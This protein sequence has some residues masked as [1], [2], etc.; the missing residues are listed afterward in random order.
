[1]R[2]ELFRN[3]LLPFSVLGLWPCA[4]LSSPVVLPSTNLQ[5]VLQTQYPGERVFVVQPGA[6]LQ[7]GNTAVVG[8]NSQNWSFTNHGTVQSTFTSTASGLLLGSLDTLGAE[9]INDGTISSTGTAF[10][11]AAGVR[12]TNGGKV[13]NLAGGVI[14][15][16]DGVHT[17]VG[18]L[19]LENA[20]TIRGTASGVYSGQGAFVV[21]L[22]GGLI[23]SASYGVHMNGP[24][25]GVFINSGTITASDN[26]FLLTGGPAVYSLHNTATGVIT[27]SGSA[28]LHLE[29]KEGQ[30]LNEGLVQSMA[31]DGIYS[32]GDLDVVINAGTVAAGGDGTGIHLKGD[33]SR[34]Y[35]LGHVAG[36][37]AGAA[38]LIEGDDSL[39]Q[40]GQSVTLPAL[41]SP[42]TGPGST[43]DGAVV[44]TGRRNSIVLTD[45]GTEDSDF[46]GFD[47]LSM[48][49][50]DWQLANTISLTG[51]A[52]D[53][54]NVRSGRLLLGGMLSSPGGSM[55]YGGQ[56][57][58]SGTA[59][60]AGDSMV[61]AGGVLN[62][63][64]SFAVGGS[65]IVDGTAAVFPSGTLKVGGDS[66]VNDGGLL[67]VAGTMGVAGNSNVNRNGRLNISGSLAVAGDS[68][69]QGAVL[70]L[71]SGVLSIGGNNTVLEGGL[72]DASG[73]TIVAGDN[74]VNQGGMLNVS[75]SFFVG[76]LN[77]VR[78]KASVFSPGSLVVGG[79]SIV[80]DGGL[81][82]VAGSVRIAGNNIVAPGSAFNISG[83]SVVEGGSAVYGR[84]SVLPSGSLT[85]G[86][87][88]AIYR[89]GLLDVAG[90]MSVTGNN[91]V[92]QGGVLRVTGVLT[93][94]GSTVVNEGGSL[95]IGDTAASPAK[96]AS[97]GT[98]LVD[99]GG[100]L[101]GTGVLEGSLENRGRVF[102]A[103]VPGGMP[104]N[105]AVQGEVRN[106]CV[107]DLRGPSPG[108][109][110]TVSAGYYGA[111]GSTLLGT[112]RLGGDS[113]SADMLRIDGGSTSGRTMVYL[114]SLSGGAPTLQP[115]PV[116][117][118]LNGATSAP[119][120]FALGRAVLS[121]L[122]EYDLKQDPASQQWYLV[123]IGPHPD[124]GS[125]LANAFAAGKLL[126]H[127]YYDRRG[128][129]EPPGIGQPAA[130]ATISGRDGAM[131]AGH[132]A[133][134]IDTS[135][136]RARAGVDLFSGTLPDGRG[137][138]QAGLMV[139]YGEARSTSSVKNN[140]RKSDGKVESWSLGVYGTW[141]ADG[142]NRS[143]AYVDS[144]FQYAKQRN[145]VHGDSLDEHRYDTHAL[146]LSLELGYIL[147]LVEDKLVL[148]PQ[149]QAVWM[150]Y[151]G[152][153]MQGPNSDIRIDDH[154]TDGWRTRLG[155]RL[156]G[157]SGVSP[158]AVLTHFAEVNWLHTS[159]TVG[160]SFD[161]Q[162][163]YLDAPDNQ[164][165]AKVGLSGRLS[166]RVNVQVQAEHRF[167]AN[168]YRDTGGAV[169][170]S[171]AW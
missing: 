36:S 89:N 159:N 14:S 28:A 42:V 106:F 20:G 8:D 51:S 96:L 134:D 11:S 54:L 140:A 85:I 158:N 69:V 66:I 127:S 67:A 24:K 92:G 7:N 47:F 18:S 167:G 93:T 102:T 103:S 162:I 61:N 40:L 53:S 117:V 3:S 131:E 129:G 37:G 87:D 21:N 156:Q 91:N 4:A 58:V 82:D 59:K 45:S 17:D 133:D 163:R 88:N 142:Q 149:A 33:H 76:G 153:A 137:A 160:I 161:R 77:A 146:A 73:S 34:L 12:F 43:L 60:V 1:M 151:R 90:T 10:S 109:S 19:Y 32:I 123:N 71:P 68:A 22:E 125:Y 141:F 122:S 15:G 136:L 107:I 29:G 56:L 97:R 64:G 5:T 101:G 84:A 170:I 52:A 144:W 169:G 79:D 9:V 111:P 164:G 121:G 143:G 26:A 124:A 150:D 78:G 132:G 139:G 152:G 41:P 16:L 49:G 6:L 72:L 63:P 86:G 25:D 75:G 50:A 118:L 145:R 31:T 70:V 30:V 94:A 46:R 135:D 171:Y 13:F 157:N 81:L 80:N 39:V 38:I 128:Q 120:S 57:E 74:A 108:Q 95:L 23:E 147:P 104:G 154:G 99:A 115:V 83:S 98:V 168:G 48:Q 62:V 55:V 130:W 65:S 2:R 35:N 105:F 110:L 148:T 112:A 113:P 155:F 119:G 27:S 138:V 44:S 100:T 166:S 126:E 116:V 114:S 165:E